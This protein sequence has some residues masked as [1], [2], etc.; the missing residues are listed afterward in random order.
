M[1]LAFTSMLSHTH[2][3]NKISYL[4]HHI[5]LKHESKSMEVEYILS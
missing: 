4:P 2:K 1:T 5:L 3:I